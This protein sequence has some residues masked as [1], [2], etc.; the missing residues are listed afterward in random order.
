MS[1][2]VIDDENGRTLVAASTSDAELCKQVKYGGNKDA[3]AV[4]GK[5]IAE[6]ALA[7]GIKQVAF[8]RYSSAPQDQCG[9]WRFPIRVSSKVQVHPSREL[10]RQIVVCAVDVSMTTGPARAR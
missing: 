6:R 2:Q 4:V 7:A 5:A 1:V 10:H 8:D 9:I 3:A